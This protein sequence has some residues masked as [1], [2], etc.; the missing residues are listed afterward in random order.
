VYVT[1]TNIGAA[2][3]TLSQPLW[4]AA[5]TRTFTFERYRYL[6]DFGGFQSL[7]K[8]EITDIEFQ[9]AGQASGLMLPTVGEVFR[10]A[11]CVFTRPRDRGITSSG[12]GCQGILID[13]CQFISNELALPALSRT[14]IALNVNANDAK[15][16]NNRI[17]RFAH[18][19]IIAGTGHMLIG[20]HFFQG[21]DELAGARRA[22]VVFTDTNLKTLMTGNYID[23]CFIELSNEHDARP[24]FDNEYSIGGL[25]I[26]GNIFTVNGAAPWFRWIVMTPRGPGHF[27][28]GLTVTDNAFR[29]VD[30]II[31]RVETVDTTHATLDATRFRNISFEANSFNG[32]TQITMSPVMVQHD[33]N[34]AADT[35]VV[36]G[37]AYM[38]FDARVRN[39]QSIVAEGAVRTAAGTTQHVMPHVELG[40]DVAGKLVHLRWPAAVR[41]RVHATLRCDTPA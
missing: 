14:T 9:C 3:V 24:E 22:G 6:L 2:T 4:A 18:F 19:A 11:D 23:N 36:N 41:G 16:R 12:S 37:G 27:I 7:N 28:N 29:T 8:F 25:T 17:V 35:W 34:T 21:D 20:N 40:P 10:V 15:I 33:Q 13:Q 5:G 30:C 31:D 32:I 26:T 1:A 39:V 38:P